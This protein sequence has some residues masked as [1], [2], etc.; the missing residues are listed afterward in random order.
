MTPSSDH[1][2]R[3]LDESGMGDF[4][5]SIFGEQ[6]N[7]VD[8]GGSGGGDYSEGSCPVS[9]QVTEEVKVNHGMFVATRQGAETFFHQVVPSQVLKV[10]NLHLMPASMPFSSSLSNEGKREP[11]LSAAQRRSGPSLV[12]LF[13][14]KSMIR[15]WIG[16]GNSIFGMLGILWIMC[17]V[18]LGDGVAYKAMLMDARFLAGEEVSRPGMSKRKR[19][20]S[21]SKR[22]SHNKQQQQQHLSVSPPANPEGTLSVCLRK[23]GFL[24]T[25]ALALSAIWIK[26]ILIT[27]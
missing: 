8:F 2:D 18:H 17:I 3:E 24:V 13:R 16:S 27:S 4:P 11:S 19:E 15:T 5:F 12:N 25:I 7:N 1:N 22:N 21:I 9:F 23:I 6:D 10:Q 26:Q 14:A 20:G